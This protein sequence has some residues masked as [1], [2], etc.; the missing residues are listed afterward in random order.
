MTDH[1]DKNLINQLVELQTQLHALTA[2]VAAEY[3]KLLDTPA[4]HHA[5]IE[6]RPS[7]HAL[8]AAFA[9][10][11]LISDAAAACLATYDD[12]G[13][14]SEESRA[15]Y[16]ALRRANVHNSAHRFV[17]VLTNRKARE[18]ARKLTPEEDAD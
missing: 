11:I 7:Y 18:A 10:E 14:V 2:Q 5:E 6:G 8:S 9:A 15:A 12:T 1:T 16:E 4:S 13:E 17:T 3:I